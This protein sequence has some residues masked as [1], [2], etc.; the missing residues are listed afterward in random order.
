MLEQKI[1]KS[2]ANF[3]ENYLPFK[4]N[5]NGDETKVGYGDDEDDDWFWASVKRVADLKSQ[6]AVSNAWWDVEP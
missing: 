6:V 1:E 2:R 3:Y 5:A 4:S